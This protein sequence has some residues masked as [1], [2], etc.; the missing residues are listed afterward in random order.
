MKLIKNI[1]SSPFDTSLVLVLILMISN[2]SIFYIYNTLALKFVTPVILGITAYIGGIV[3]SKTLRKEPTIGYTKQFALYSLIFS[4]IWFFYIS[5]FFIGEF[6]NLIF[7]LVDLASLVALGLISLII[8][9]YLVE[10][11][12]IFGARKGLN[13]SNYEL[14]ELPQVNKI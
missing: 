6:Y 7:N 8:N 11:M 5:M 10:Y 2:I 9:F 14:M 1:L 13:K 12:F 3:Y 4:R